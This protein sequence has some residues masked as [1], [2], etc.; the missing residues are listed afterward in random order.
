MDRPRERSSYFAAGPYLILK[1]FPEDRRCS[2]VFF[3]T[4]ASFSRNLWLL[5]IG[6]VVGFGVVLFYLAVTAYLIARV[7]RYSGAWRERVALLASL[8]IILTYLFQAFG[9][10][11]LVNSQF[12]FFV[13][14][15][16]A[17]AGRLAAR[18]R[19][20][21]RRLPAPPGRGAPAAE[22]LTSHWA[23]SPLSR[24]T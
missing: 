16:V 13:S 7:L 2:S 23:H 6:G 3:W 11:G 19:V 12:C 18:Y 24:A 8:S 10:M 14:G 20:L 22:G 15:A 1:A 9:D 5:W 21:E 4:S 17:I